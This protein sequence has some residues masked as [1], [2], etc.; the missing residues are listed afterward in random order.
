MGPRLCAKVCGSARR[1]H[2]S[3][4][5]VGSFVHKARAIV[6]KKTLNA[7]ISQYAHITCQ[8]KYNQKL[9]ASSLATQPESRKQV[10]PLTNEKRMKKSNRIF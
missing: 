10:I 6:Y 8:S 4:R 7:R 2:V 1:L 9:K 5:D 3:M